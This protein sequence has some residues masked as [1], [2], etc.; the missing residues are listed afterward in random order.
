M[1]KFY[2]GNIACAEGAIAAGCRFFAGYPITPSTEIAEH[3]ALRL[4]QVGGIFIQMEDE[5]A[6]M[7]AILGASWGGMKA[8]TA[9]S[10]PGLSLMQE[11]IGLGAMTETPCVVVDVQRAGPSTGMPTLIGQADVM[12]ARWGSHGDYEIIALSPSSPQECFDLTIKSFNL[13]EEYRVPVILLMDESVSH[14]SEKVIIP[15]KEKIKIVERKKPKV[16]PS[17]YLPFKADDYV[18]PMACAGEGYAVHVTGLTHDEKGYPQATSPEVQEKLVRRLCDKIRKNERKLRDIEEFEMEDAKLAIVSFGTTARSCKAAVKRARK[19]GYKVGL[20]RLRTIW[21]FADEYFEKIANEIK[22]FVVV[23]VNY[24][25]IKLEVERCVGKK[26]HLLPKM[27]GEI[28]KPEEIYKK[29]KEV[30]NG[31]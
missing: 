31:N 18:P 8:M 28:H 5:L 4:P 15:P 16:K 20:I 1:I 23:E 11:N 22:Q 27:G 12:Q 6:S 7:A 2:S 30:Y 17:E 25:Q 9:T 13:A 26:V 24:G 14:M 3:M 21:P 29:I 10:G 19:R